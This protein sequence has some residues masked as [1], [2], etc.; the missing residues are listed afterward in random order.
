MHKKNHELSSWSPVPP[1]EDSLH[2][3][4]TRPNNLPTSPNNF[5]TW[6]NNCQLEPATCLPTCN[7][8]TTCNLQLALNKIDLALLG[9]F[10]LAPNPGS[11]GAGSWLI[12]LVLWNRGLKRLVTQHRLPSFITI[13][14]ASPPI[15]WHGMADSSPSPTLEE[16]IIRYFKWKL[17]AECFES[18]WYD[19]AEL[20]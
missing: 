15:C 10:G 8:L 5:P 17:E 13:A 14:L 6:P 18:I 3:N 16:Q 2:V 9:R 12:Y 11:G 1:I 7:L 20:Y 4:F 19:S